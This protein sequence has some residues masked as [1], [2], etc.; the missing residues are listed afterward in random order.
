MY[1]CPICK[2]ELDGSKCVRCAMEFELGDGVPVFF[3]QSSISKR[4]REIGLFYDSL[5]QIKEDAWKDLAG[6]GREVI[7][8][9]ASLV[10]SYGPERFLDAGCGQGFL[11]E[12]VSAREKFG[13]EISRKA[14]SIAN[15]RSNATFCQGCIEELPYA[16]NSF[17]VV[18]G[19]GII[20]HLLDHISATKEIHRVLRMGGIYIL[21]SD[22]GISVTE[23]IMIKVSEFVYPRFRPLSLILWVQRKCFRLVKKQFVRDHSEDDV[24]QP[25][26]IAFTEIGLKKL[27]KST[28]FEIVRSITKR[29]CPDAPLEGHYFKIYVLKKRKARSSDPNLQ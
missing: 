10:E 24:R 7:E 9:M 28:G 27:F 21:G 26:Q 1:V 15:S 4:Y 23:R 11:L 12:A 3:T 29:K 2:K 17:N 6:R 16:E 8:Y 19:I 13:I 18:T 22:L 20:T 25:V 14:I 5:Y